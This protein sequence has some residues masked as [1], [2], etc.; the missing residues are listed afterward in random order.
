ML[1]KVVYKSNTTEI[2]NVDV[3]GLETGIY[4]VEMTTLDKRRVVKKLVKQ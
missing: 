2:G 4:L 3:S 1:G